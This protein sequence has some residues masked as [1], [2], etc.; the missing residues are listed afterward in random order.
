[1]TDDLHYLALDPG[2]KRQGWAKFNEE[3]TTI[4][5]G[6]ITGDLDNFMDWLEGLDPPPKVIIYENYRVNPTIKHGF[7][8]VPTVQLIGMIKRFAK[9]AKIEI[10]EQNNG[11]LPIGLRYAG[12]FDRYYHANGKK[13]KH[14]DDEHAALAHGIY[15]LVKN[16]IR[17]HRLATDG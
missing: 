7:S 1:M 3:G 9:K 13:K 8:K 2:E 11:V 10:H 17:E 6:K 15:Y 14:V 16:K 4:G 12:F 5:F